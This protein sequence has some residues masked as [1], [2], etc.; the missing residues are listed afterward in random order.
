MKSGTYFTN[1][2]E[3]AKQYGNIVYQFKADE[4]TILLF[5]KDCFNEHFIS[6]R[7]IPFYIFDILVFEIW[8]DVKGYEGIYEVSNL[9]RVKSLKLGRIKIM[10]S[11]PNSDGY[12]RLNLTKMGK[13][14]NFKVH[15]LVAVAFLGHIPCGLD[16]VIN[17]KDFNRQNNH[18]DNLEIVSSRENGNQ[19]H[20]ISSSKYTGVSWVKS[21]NKWLAQI[22]INGKQKNL[23]R[24]VN[25]YDAHLAYEKALSKSI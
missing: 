2:L 14:N 22:L 1:D 4:K 25:E 18:V 12:L 8:K 16:L 15:Q 17:H 19:K 23:G 20:L 11:N 10:K 9:G 13:G 24:F 7:I 3:V 21:R 5:Y 6:S